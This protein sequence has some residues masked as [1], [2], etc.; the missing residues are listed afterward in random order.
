MD[1][2]QKG[3]VFDHPAVKGRE[4][5]DFTKKYQL[6]TPAELKHSFQVQTPVF[7]SVL[8]QSVPCVGCRRSVERL[9]YQLMLSGHPTLDP[10]VITNKG[11]LTVRDDKLRS[12]QAICSLLYKHNV[13]LNSLLEN[14]PR[15]KK[16]SRC[17]L[18]SL[19]SFRSRPF[20]EMWRDVWNCMKQQCK[21]EIAVVEASE[22][23]ATLDGYLKKHKFCQ[24]CRTK[25]TTKYKLVHL[26]LTLLYSDVF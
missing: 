13:L 8:S 9:F 12:S 6:L 11:V 10:I 22:L 14:Q 4:L 26:N 21:D 25:V 2:S 24:D 1:L 7:T 15:N 16:S 3:L 23:H 18:H 20:S 5:E 17:S 19:D